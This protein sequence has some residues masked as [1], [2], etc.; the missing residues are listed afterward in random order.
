MR[1]N[2]SARVG[3]LSRQFEVSD[4]TV[5]RDI[6]GLAARGLVHK[7]HGGATA[8]EYAGSE[9]PSFDAKTTLEHD[10]KE[11]I[12][13]A[14]A[15]M[16][17]PGAAVALSAGT[18]TWVLAK[19]L[20]RIPGLTVVTNS[21]R[22]ATEL[23][24]TPGERTLIVT[25]GTPTPSDALT[26]PAAD[27]VIGSLRFDLLFLGCHGMDETS[28]FSTPNLAEAQTNRTLISRA[29]Q[30]VVV[31]DSTKWGAVGLA[32]F[33]ALD[34]ADVVITDDRLPRAARKALQ[35]AA[36]ELIVVPADP[37]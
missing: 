24:G 21:L 2:G 32:S 4:M 37:S 1:R 10:A 35:D 31:A 14:A 5:R 16:V 33:G 17:R 15:E 29:R 7:V 23:H 3:E 12:A 30:V 18:T 11:Q 8:L 9:E 6:D 13:R 22:V 27:L 26:G 20:A 34:A 25:G 36:G 28:G 19:H